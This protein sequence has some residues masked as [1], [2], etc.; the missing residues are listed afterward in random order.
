MKFQCFAALEIVGSS[1]RGACK[2][3]ERLKEPFSLTAAMT[4]PR[5]A[6]NLHVACTAC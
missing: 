4:T 2:A 5:K 3:M 6:C 1:K